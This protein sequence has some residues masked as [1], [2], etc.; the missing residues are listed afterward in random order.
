MWDF[1]QRQLVI[2]W[3]NHQGPLDVV[4]LKALGVVMVILKASEGSGYRDPFFADNVQKAKDAGFLVGA[5]HFGVGGSDP[6]VQADLFLS[7]VTDP[8]VA[9]LLDMESEAP[10]PDP[11]LAWATAFC[12]RVRQSGRQ[13][14]VRM[15]YTGRW[16]WCGHLGNPIELGLGWLWDSNYVLG[17]GTPWEILGNAKPGD[18][19]APGVT[20]DLFVPYGG[21]TLE[22]RA[23]RQYTS[24]GQ[25]G[26][27]Q[28]DCSVFYGS[29]QALHDIFFPGGQWPAPLSVTPTSVGGSITAPARLSPGAFLQS[30]N[31]KYKLVM[32]SDGNL[33]LYALGSD[34]VW[35]SKTY[36]SPAA[37]ADF[38]AD[39]NLVIYDLTSKPIW[40]TGTAGRG[41]H[42]LAMQDDGN[43]VMYGPMGP[44]WAF[45]G[46]HTPAVPGFP[47]PAGYVFG[48]GPGK[49]DGSTSHRGDLALWQKRMHDR[50]WNITSTGLY[51]AATSTVVHAFQTEKK[52][53]VDGLIGPATWAAAWALPIS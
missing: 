31:G 14:Q 1:T 46:A 29:L 22:T 34:P 12:Q 3:S 9:L 8:D 49:V 6:V 32:Q 48:W 2:D 23:L 41:G 36:G 7:M 47:L 19:S 13:I 11:D 51:D 18:T 37:F 20:P 4:N 38:Q 50:G 24:S 53:A 5:Y 25:V 10:N 42:L 28:V 52:L 15:I 33:V 43:L 44:I 27:K 26:D 16:Y 21:W 45:L 40:S 35:S 17:S 39:G 30:P